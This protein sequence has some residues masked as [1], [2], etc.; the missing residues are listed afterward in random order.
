R[1][2]I[3]EGMVGA[4]SPGGTAFPFFEWNQG[5]AL[6]DAKA[7]PLV[8]VACKTGT[9]QH[10]GKQTKP[11]AWIVVTGPIVKEEGIYK[12]DLESKKRII[13]VV[14][15][16]EAGEGSYE[17]GPVAKNILEKRFKGN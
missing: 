6:A 17:A 16:E 2:L 8:S 7:R 1:N 10:G 9:A 15:L 3:L 4:C 12:L 13:L 5:L 14:M 11:H